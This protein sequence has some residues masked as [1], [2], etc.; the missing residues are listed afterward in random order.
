MNQ[1]LIALLATTLLACAI[2]G[3]ARAQSTTTVTTTATI[4]S[5]CKFQNGANGLALAFPDI[6][7]AGVEA[8]T[9]ELK[10]K[11]SCTKNSAVKFAVNDKQTGSAD[12]TLSDGANS[13]AYKVTWNGP[14]NLSAGGLTKGHSEANWATVTLTGSITREAFQ[15]AVAGN[16]T[17]NTGLK[18]SVNP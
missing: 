3:N 14:E 7:P 10:V 12:G 15:D 13:L 11:F 6:D 1:R 9:R 2:A 17:D 5:T 16:Y 4:L 8:V 18:L